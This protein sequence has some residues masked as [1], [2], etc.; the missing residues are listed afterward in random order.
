MILT[1]VRHRHRTIVLASVCF[2]HTRY[3]DIQVEKVY[4]CIEIHRIK[5]HK[6]IVAD[7]VNAQV[8]VGEEQECNH[9]GRHAYG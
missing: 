8:G 4:R 7:D 6:T 3:S 1:M 9:V 5:T 2:P